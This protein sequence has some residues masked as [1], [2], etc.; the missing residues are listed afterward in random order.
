MPRNANK[1]LRHEQGGFLGRPLFMQCLL[2]SRP[3][4]LVS[5]QRIAAH[6]VVTATAGVTGSSAEGQRCTGHP[7]FYPSRGLRGFEP[8]VVR[9]P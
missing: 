4:L 9:L 5:G 6:T 3:G 2:Y 8:G 7:G 1:K